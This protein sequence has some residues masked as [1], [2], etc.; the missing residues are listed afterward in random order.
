MTTIID[1][2]GTPSVVFNR[3]GTAIITLVGLGSATTV[4][5]PHFSETTVVIAT[6]SA[7]GRD[8]FQM[9]SGFEIGDEVEFNWG[10]LSG[11]TINDENGNLIVCASGLHSSQMRKKSSGMGQNWTLLKGN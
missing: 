7:N 10:S 1:P 6:K 2:A 11:V 8:V 9:A 5:I 3:S 4:P